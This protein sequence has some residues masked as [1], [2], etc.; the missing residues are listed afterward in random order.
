M[1]SSWPRVKCKINKFFDA[2]H[3]LPQM[4]RA[5]L[6][7]HSYWA[8]FGYW[9]EI[10]PTTGVTK[11]I[12]DMMKDL[13]VVVERVSG[14]NL[15]EV[16]PVTPTLEFLACWMLCQLPAYWEFVVIRGYGCYEVEIHRDWLTEN[17]KKVLE[18]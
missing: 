13:D 3:S 6:H 5:E 9:H 16:L 12:D 18:K 11:T 2:D 14:K 17:W 8:E 7:R 15:N 1:K 4:G 10:N